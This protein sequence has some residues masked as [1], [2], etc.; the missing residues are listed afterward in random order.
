MDTLYIYIMAHS[1]INNEPFLTSFIMGTLLICQTNTENDGTY[2]QIDLFNTLNVPIQLDS[3]QVSGDTNDFVLRQINFYNNNGVETVNPPFYIQPDSI[4]AI[5]SYFFNPLDT[6]W[7]IATLKV[8]IHSSIYG[9]QTF[10][11]MLEGYGELSSNITFMGTA[12]GELIY[13]H[14]F[15]NN[16]DSTNKFY[17]QNCGDTVLINASFIGRNSSNLS[18][19]NQP[20]QFTMLQEILN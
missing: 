13:S 7:R 2:G 19:I 14:I 3:I 18:F 4:P 1:F 16:C 5:F 8:F 9:A 12:N 6:G 20:S 15:I 10:S 17:I 11:G